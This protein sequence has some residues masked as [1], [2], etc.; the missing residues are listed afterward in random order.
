M[1]PDDVIR[2]F[3]Q[4]ALDDDLDLEVDDAIALLA[5]VLADEAIEGKVRRR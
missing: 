5:A 1:D 4:L 2:R 3:E